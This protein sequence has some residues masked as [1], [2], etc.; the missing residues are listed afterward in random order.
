MYSISELKAKGFKETISDNERTNFPGYWINQEGNVYSTYSN[1]FLRIL[2]KNEKQFAYHIPTP[3]EGGYKYT[4]LNRL[5]NEYFPE[6]DLKEFVKIGP[7][8]PYHYINKD[9]IVYSEWTEKF[10]HPRVGN[11][12]CDFHLRN[13]KLK[14]VKTVRQ[15]HLLLMAFRPEEFKKVSRGVGTRDENGVRWSVDHINGIK[16]DNRLENLEV[17]TQKEN[18]L[19]ASENGLLKQMK[20]MKTRDYYTGEIKR[21][22]SITELANDIGIDHFACQERLKK[23]KLKFGR[24]DNRLWKEGIQVK[25]DNDDTPWPE[26][27]DILGARS[28]R[29]FLIKDFK[30]SPNHEKIVPNMAKLKD[31]F[32][33]I[34]TK[35]LE[36]L[37][38]G[39]HP[40][41]NN[42][43]QVKLFTDLREWSLVTDPYLEVTKNGRKGNVVAVYKDNEPA[44]I[45]LPMPGSRNFLGLNSKCV[46]NF[47]MRS[48]RYKDYN[49]VLY[50]DYV[51]TEHYKKFR[52]QNTFDVTQFPDLNK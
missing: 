14:K 21:Y 27:V 38:N 28:D 33:I 52:Y 40:M 30:V 34:E 41:L 20:P 50:Q 24:I 22:L 13:E 51:R 8:Y 2:G 17:V 47:S 32:G 4:T 37:N 31:M 11:G 35:L 10:I 43:V 12:Y 18:C 15:H 5:M 25:Y 29:A 44:T 3:W 19:R 26:P 42:L 39:K 9:G 36:D 23:S 49:I 16:T 6:Y 46:Y 7:E 48:N 45:L 1:K